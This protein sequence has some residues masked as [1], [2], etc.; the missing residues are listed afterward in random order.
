MDQTEVQFNQRKPL[1]LLAYLAVTG[2][3]HSRATLA[4]LL[5]PDYAGARNYLRNVLSSVRQVDRGKL[6]R[7]LGH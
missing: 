6:A 7:F 5:W 4:T 2:Q 1:A 3:S